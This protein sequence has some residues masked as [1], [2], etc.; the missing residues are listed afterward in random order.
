MKPT[1]KLNRRSFLGTVA[2][3][4]AGAG[5]LAA[6]SGEA[7]AFQSGCSDNDRGQNADPINNGRSCRTSGCSDNDSGQNSDPIGNGRSW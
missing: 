7:H 5:A 6:V 2:G 1:R 3:G 4:V